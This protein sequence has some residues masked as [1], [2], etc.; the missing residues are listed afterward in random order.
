[1]SWNTDP[2]HGLLFRPYEENDRA[3]CLDIFDGNVPRYFDRSERAGFTEDLE[4][5][6]SR[7][8]YF[9]LIQHARIIGCG[10]LVISS[11]GTRS[12]LSWGMVDPA[13]QRRGM[14]AALLRYRLAYLQTM[15]LMRAVELSTSQHTQGFYQRFGFAVVDVVRDGF[16]PGLD[17][18]DMVLHL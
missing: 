14:G 3:A 8:P 9:V 10:G 1:L 12:G 17:R 4:R 5:S 13:H 15:P 11:D 16:G 7:T 6:G 18:V 2:E